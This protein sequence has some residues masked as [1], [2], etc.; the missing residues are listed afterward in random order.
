MVSNLIRHGRACPGHPRL[1]YRTSLAVDARDK[2]GHDDRESDRRHKRPPIA[3]P[4]IE[5]QPAEIRPIVVDAPAR[6]YDSILTIPT[7]DALT[8]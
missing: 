5:V 1:T 4:I 2:P 3:Y 8:G 7:L 6:Q